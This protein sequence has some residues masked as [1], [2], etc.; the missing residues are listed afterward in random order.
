MKK[1]LFLSAMA[2]ML[3]MTAMAQEKK[4]TKGFN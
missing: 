3:G 2:L 4:S 1:T